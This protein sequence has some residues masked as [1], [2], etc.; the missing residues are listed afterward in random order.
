MT[1][2]LFF[3][4]NTIDTQFFVAKYPHENQKAK[5]SE[6][7]L[8][9]GGPATNAAITFAYLGGESKLAS[10]FGNHFLTSLVLHDIQRFGVQTIDITPD[11]TCHPIFASVVTSNGNRSVVSYHPTNHNYCFST[12]DSFSVNEF[13][14][15]LIDSF[16]IDAA[17]ALLKK[18]T[19]NIPVVLDGGSWKP[20]LEKLLP[21][22]T[23][24]ICSEDFYPPGTTSTHEV[25]DYLASFGIQK[26]AITRGEN[27]LLVFEEN[28]PVELP[29][30]KIKAI[31][32]FGA[33]D[34]FHGAFCYYY[35][36]NNNFIAALSKASEIAAKS[37]LFF[38]PR[39][40]MEVSS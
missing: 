25:I 36:Q 35:A 24:A 23:I 6:F 27:P 17:I 39:K 33:G 20:G 21:Y 9:A 29:V 4:L 32:S 34:I 37:C 26:I 14:I 40:W 11:R 12:L 30:Q 15:M 13:D 18:S 5:A 10:S 19:N 1:K 7:G 38:G 2:A 22:V 31:D 28:N 8:Y 3:G 16:Y